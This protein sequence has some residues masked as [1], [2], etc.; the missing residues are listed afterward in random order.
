[1]TKE[2]FI[3]KYDHNIRVTFREYEQYKSDLNEVI[4]DE[5]KKF[6]DYH[7]TKNPD[8]YITNEFIQQYLNQ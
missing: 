6:V 7:T 1:M 4:K 5:I 2:E 8:I 3:I